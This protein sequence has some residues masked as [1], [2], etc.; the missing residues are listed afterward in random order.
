MTFAVHVTLPSGKVLYMVF[1]GIVDDIPFVV[2]SSRE[3][4]L[5]RMTHCFGFD[6][7]V[8]PATPENVRAML[9]EIAAHYGIPGCRFASTL[10]PS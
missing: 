5:S 8:S 4:Y 2:W 1:R 10:L 3:E 6:G 9:E 7:S